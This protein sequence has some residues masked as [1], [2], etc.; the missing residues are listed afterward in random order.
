MAWCAK[1]HLTGDLRPSNKF[2]LDSPQLCLVFVRLSYTIFWPNSLET[3]RNAVRSSTCFSVPAHPTSLLFRPP[4]SRRP[5]VRFRPSTT[6]STQRGSGII[7]ATSTLI[8]G[9]IQYTE[10]NSRYQSIPC[11]KSRCSQPIEAAD[12]SVAAYQTSGR[13]LDGT[14]A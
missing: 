7:R 8:D 13:T 6:S 3:E 9:G 14:E 5:S 12:K 4:S 2:L 11:C 10:V 1:R